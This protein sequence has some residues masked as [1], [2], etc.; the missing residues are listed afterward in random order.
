VEA[1]A[2]DGYSQRV[3]AGEIRVRQVAGVM[4]LAEHVRARLTR[5]GPPALDATLERA[6]LA[7]RKPPWI[8]LQEPVEQRLGVQARLRFQP[9][10]DP[11][12][13]VCQRV[14]PRP[15]DAWPLLRAGQGTQRAIFAC[16][17][18]V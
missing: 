1:F 16:R 15:I 10:L 14:L 8:R 2:E 5:R 17:F 11:M 9:F 13:Q 3:H 12:P 6:A 18:F 4:H 7:L